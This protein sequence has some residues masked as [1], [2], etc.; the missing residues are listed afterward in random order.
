L[1]P[2]ILVYP[3][4]RL[5][6][7]CPPVEHFDGKLRTLAE[8]M[9]KLMVAKHGIG[10]AGPQVGFL[11]RMFVC[12]V[13]GQP[14]DSMVFINPELVDLTGGVEGDEGCLSIPN[15]TVPVRR[16]ERCVIR[17]CDVDG[18]SFEITGEGLLARV[19][20]HE[21]DHLDGKLILDRTSSTAKLSVRRTVKELESK[22]RPSKAAAR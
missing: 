15:V 6:K 21:N 3:D 13:T 11:R 20:Q 2:S 4:P 22:H 19:W 18:N 12:N 14:A 16:A 9:L 8:A 10:L 17:A 1:S 7:V 5:R